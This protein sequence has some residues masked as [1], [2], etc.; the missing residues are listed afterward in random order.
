ML[1]S[2]LC[3]NFWPNPIAMEFLRRVDVLFFDEAGTLSAE[4]L[5]VLDRVMRRIENSSVLMGGMLIISMMD[6]LQLPPF[7]G[8]PFLMSSHIL[9]CF[10]TVHLEHSTRSCHDSPFQWLQQI[11][12]TFQPTES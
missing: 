10:R 6:P 1:Q 8:C 11:L 2:L 4:L 3:S 12:R 7:K 9:H 5:S